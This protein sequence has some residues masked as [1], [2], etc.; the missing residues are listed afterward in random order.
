MSRFNSFANIINAGGYKLGEMKERIHGL[1]DRGELTLD[2]RDRLLGMAE[3]HADP[4]AET[5]KGNM[6]ADHER[7]IK[8]LEDKIAELM[9]QSGETEDGE[10]NVAD[11]AEYVPGK[12]Y[13][14]GDVVM[15]NSEA[16]VCTAP[17]GV[18]CVW[19]PA[20]Y[21]AYWEKV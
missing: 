17:G 9:N 18:V 10:L 19:S 20:D 13:Y 3:T 1:A 16:Y 7:R 8:A 21:P 15:W 2:E 4:L 5:E 6:L 11:I 14:A 12:W